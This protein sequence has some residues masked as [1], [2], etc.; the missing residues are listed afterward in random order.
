[1]SRRW[2]LGLVVAA[3]V[4]V[5]LLMPTVSFA[6][7]KLIKAAKKEGEVVLYHSMSRRVLKEVVKGFEKKYGIKG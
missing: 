6:D 4:S 5:G 7:E 1:M 2:I 3:F